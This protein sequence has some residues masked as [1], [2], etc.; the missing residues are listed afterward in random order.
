MKGR[1]G[2]VF[3]VGAVGITAGLYV[4]LRPIFTDR[5]DTGAAGSLFYGLLVSFGAVATSFLLLRRAIVASHR[6]FQLAFFG[7]LLGRLVLFGV[8]VGGAFLSARLD[9]RAVAAAILAGFL[10]LTALEVFCLVR[11]MPRRDLAETK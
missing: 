11:G 8:A 9:G 1:F 5:F 10:P 2:S 7:G 3:A 4:A 6:S